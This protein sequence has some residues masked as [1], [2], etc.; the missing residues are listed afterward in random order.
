MFNDRFY[1]QGQTAPKK[2]AQRKRGEV[3]ATRTISGVAA[4]DLWRKIQFR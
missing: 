4:G 2:I 1:A 3:R